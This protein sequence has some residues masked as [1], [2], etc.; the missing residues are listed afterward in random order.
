MNFTTSLVLENDMPLMTV[1]FFL[2][3]FDEGLNSTFK[4]GRTDL[5]R[6]PTFMRCVSGASEVYALVAFDGSIPWTTYIKALPDMMVF[7]DNGK[8]VSIL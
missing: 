1:R 6:F 3:P 8:Y 5:I 2:I 4:R 7:I